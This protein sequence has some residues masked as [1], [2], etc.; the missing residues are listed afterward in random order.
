RIEA[1]RGYHDVA[2]IFLVATKYS[3][4]RSAPSALSWA[5]RRSFTRGSDEENSAL[6]V[7][8][9]HAGIG[10]DAIGAQ[11]RRSAVGQRGG[12]SRP[13]LRADRT[14]S[15]WGI[16]LFDE[17]RKHPPAEPAAAG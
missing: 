3:A 14:D 7:A 2:S 8:D 4:R 15:K 13:P 9:R 10:S 12:G 6:L 5:R 1:H 16:G 11:G 17:V